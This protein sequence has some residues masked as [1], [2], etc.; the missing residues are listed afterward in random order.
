MMT[1]AFLKPGKLRRDN[2]NVNHHQHGTGSHFGTYG[3]GPVRQIRQFSRPVPL[4]HGQPATSTAG[5]AGAAAVARSHCSIAQF[6]PNLFIGE[7]HIGDRDSLQQSHLSLLLFLP[8]DQV[9][10]DW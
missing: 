2:S 9:G 4:P 5:T 7:H 6:P 10:T 1:N 8:A 3:S